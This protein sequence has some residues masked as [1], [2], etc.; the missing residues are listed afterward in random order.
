MVARRRKYKRRKSTFTLNKTNVGLSLIILW[1]LYF[2]SLFMAE[3]SPLFEILTEYA[4]IWF[5]EIWLNVFFALCVLS[6][7]LIMLKWYLM[8]TIVK[9][10]VLLMILISWLLNFPII[11]N[12]LIQ[13]TTTNFAENWW[14][15]SRPLLRVLDTMFG[16][17]ATAIKAFI[18][19]LF[20]VLIWRIIYSF[21]ISLPK[22]SVNVAQYDKPKKTTSKA[23]SAN[24]PE[25]I[26][27]PDP[28]PTTNQSREESKSFI[29]TL[30]K[31]K[32][33]QK[34]QEQEVKKFVP[35]KFSG[36]K[37]TF[38]ANTLSISTVESQQ[39]NETFLVE[40]AHWL[41]D[42]LSEFNVPV[43]VE[44]F[45]IWPSIVQIRVKP[46]QWIRISAIE[47]LWNDIKL[48]LKTRSLRIVAPIPGTDTVWIQIPNPKPTMVQL[49]DIISSNKFQMEM[50]ESDTAMALWKW[51]DGS[52]VVKD[53]ESMPHLLVAWATWSWKSVWVNDFILSLMHQNTPS[54][55]KFLMIDPKQVELELYS[56]LPYMLGPIVSDPDKALKLLRRSVEEMERRYWLLKEKRVKNLQEYNTKIIWE[57]MYRIVVV[58]DE[59]ADMMMHKNKKDVETCITRIAQKARAVW[60][61]LIVATQRPSVNVITW[62]IKANIP[63][64]IAF[65][66]VSEIDSRTI[67]GRKWAEDLL[68]KWDL[69]YID[70][71]TKHPTRVQ[72]PFVSTEDIEEVV[73][74]LKEKYMQWL[75]ENDIYHPEIVSVLES[76][77]EIWSGIWS[78]SW[79]WGSD[80]ELIQQ[81]IQIV[82][83]TRKA[84]ATLLQRRLNVWFAR[85]ARIMDALEERG[86]VWPQ[87][88]A[89]ARE[90]F[91]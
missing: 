33:A 50:K 26:P 31:Q 34:T 37:P 63:T 32:V 67:I 8:K 41:K 86:I 61:H 74:T 12:W 48:S 35:I 16:S 66:V 56:W 27:T 5:W 57:K 7:I 52:I 72:A 21:N 4:S 53:L 39:I 19:I 90:I 22:F 79:W 2:F 73:K 36:D 30:I 78:W 84:S 58:I 6:G 28:K 87:Q 65:W 46:E 69:L 43:T 54:E 75:T 62:L 82:S 60:I 40:K 91:I 83:E 10:S 38:P 76:K 55:L 18:I 47:N 14:Y 11:D 25:R 44:W 1:W 24:K 29:K 45:D 88:W 3:W 71:K 89:K 15:I 80:E 81:A 49:W 85:A 70:T 13:A 17:Q 64:R 77:V 68:W 59:L 51:I 23:T 9:Q 20:I 42:K